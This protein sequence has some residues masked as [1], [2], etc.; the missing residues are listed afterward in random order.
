MNLKDA[1]RAQNKLQA[2]MEEAAGILRDRNNILNVATTHLRSRVMPE[3]QDAVTEAPHPSPF[4]DHINEVAAFLMAM[5]AEREKLCAAIHQAKA[6]LPLD[7]DSEV[8]LNRVRQ[9]LAETFRR[10]AALRSGE[11]L[12]P[13]GGSG[14]RFNGEGNQVSYCCDAREVTTIN[15]DRNK[16]R[17]KAAQLGRQSDGISAQ[18]DKCLVNTSVDYTLPFDMN[19]GFDVILSDFIEKQP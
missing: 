15:F 16:I 3:A 10:M 19:D 6:A 13:G 1:F 9:D 4:A 11:V 14:Y 8:G 2:V 5:L 12:L 7:M 18:L 17:G